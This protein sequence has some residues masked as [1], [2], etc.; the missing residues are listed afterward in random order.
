MRGGPR[1]TLRVSLLGEVLPSG[2]KG[3][4]RA[5]LGWARREQAGST[6]TRDTVLL[7]PEAGALVA[8][9]AEQRQHFHS[10]GSSQGSPAPQR[11]PP[12]HGRLCV[13]T[14]TSTTFVRVPGL[15]AFGADARVLAISGMPPAPRLSPSSLPAH[16][17]APLLFSP[18]T[19]DSREGHQGP[20]VATLE[21]ASPSPAHL[22]GLLGA[23]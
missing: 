13:E 18:T 6:C 21:P 7:D 15:G 3:G 14:S 19:V 1:P 2:P 12:L 23:P 20:C 22:S 17:A 4:A 11:L 9:E 16:P 8:R 10:R 5:A